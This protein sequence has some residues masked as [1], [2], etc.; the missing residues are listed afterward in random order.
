MSSIDPVMGLSC[1]FDLVFGLLDVQVFT[2]FVAFVESP[3]DVR[4]SQM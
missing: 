1:S 4:D 3:L 2:W